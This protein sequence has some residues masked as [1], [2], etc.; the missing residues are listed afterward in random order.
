MVND[1]LQDDIVS[2][3]IIPSIK[4]DHS[5]ITLSIN[6]IDN[7][8][9]G[10]SFWKFNWSLVNDKNYCNLLDRNKKSWFQEFK[11][12]VDKRVLW[13]LLKYKIRQLTINY[14]KLKSSEPVS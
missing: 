8:K 7:S 11:G 4:S 6:G 12:V 13:D 9:R 10:P 3:D 1:S 14:S 2:V 5:A